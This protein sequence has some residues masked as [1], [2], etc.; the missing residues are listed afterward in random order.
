MLQFFV[1]VRERSSVLYVEFLYFVLILGKVAERSVKREMHGIKGN[2]L[3]DRV[4]VPEGTVCTILRNKKNISGSDRGD[5][6]FAMQKTVP[7]EHDREG[8]EGPG[9]SIVIAFIVMGIH[10]FVY[11]QRRNIDI[12]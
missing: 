12:D 5:F 11:D 2:F 7:F 6:S 8:M 1:F 4:D 10:I 3:T 9:R